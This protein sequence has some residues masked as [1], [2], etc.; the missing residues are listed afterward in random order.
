MLHNGLA[1]SRFEIAVPL[2]FKFLFDLVEGFAGHTGIDAHQ[3]VD[4]ILALGVAHTGFAVRYGAL[5][6][7]HDVVGLIEH[8]DIGVGI[9]VGLAHLA[10]RILKRH[11]ARVRLGNVSVRYGKGGAVNAVEA[12]RNI[13]GKLKVLLL[14]RANRDKL[15]LI[16]QNIGGHQAGIGEQS[17]VDVFRMLGGFI[18]ELRH[19]GKFAELGV[20]VENPCQL[21]VGVHLALNKEDAFLH[22]DAA[23]HQQ[24]VGFQCIMPEFCG[25]LTHRNG[26]Q[27]RQSIDAVVFVLQ[28]GAVFPRAEIIPQSDGTAGLDSTENNFFTFCCFHENSSKVF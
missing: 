13:A 15:R 11:N 4:T 19:A 25:I 16:Q 24:S 2:A 22:I 21:G 8:R 27:I 18:L 10:G 6:F 20:A 28:S 23:G 7:A 14:I 12:F 3:V 26:V 9:L 17:G 1:D 5:E